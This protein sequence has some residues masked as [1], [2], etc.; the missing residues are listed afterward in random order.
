[1]AKAVVALG[2]NVGNRVQ[3]L[4]DAKQFLKSISQYDVRSSSIYLTEPVGPSSRYFLNAVVEITITMKPGT[5][6]NEFKTFERKHGRTA[7]QPRWSARTIDLDIISYDNLV[8]QEDNLIIPHPEY[9]SRL[10]VLKPLKELHNDW[11]D[12]KTDISISQLITNA[13]PLK[14]KKT[15][16]TW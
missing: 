10:F 1:M 4:K 5:L 11:K 7:D 9:R 16:L 8:I 2:S 3:H 15:D 12:P 14:M 6:I 13:P